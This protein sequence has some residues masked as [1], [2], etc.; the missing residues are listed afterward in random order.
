MADDKSKVGHPDKDLISIKEDYEK[1]DWAR[2]FGVTEA[3]LVK[4]VIAVGHSAKKVE[5][6]LKN[7]K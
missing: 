1:R 4:A 7:N 5:E 2:K 3:K 6:W